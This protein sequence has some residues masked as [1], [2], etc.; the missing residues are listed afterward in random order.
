MIPQKAIKKITK[1]A[2]REIVVGHLIAYGF[3]PQTSDGIAQAEKFVAGLD[4][5]IAPSDLPNYYDGI[6]SDLITG[7][8]TAGI[9][10]IKMILEEFYFGGGASQEPEEIPVEMEIVEV[11]QKDSDDPIVV[12]VEAPFVN[13]VT[14]RT[15]R[16]I[17][18]PRVR[19]TIPKSKIPQQKKKDAATRMAESFDRRLDDLLDKIKNPDPTAPPRVRKPKQV[20]VKKSKKVKVNTDIKTDDPYKADTFNKFLGLKI[21][22]AFKR[23]ASARR[24]AKESGADPKGRGYFLKKALAFEFGGDKLS[25][26]KGTFS[27]DPSRVND[28]ALT[29]DQRFLAGIGDDI[30]PP[31]VKQSEL[32][33]TTQYNNKTG[34]QKIF[35]G[36]IDKLKNSFSKVEKGLNDLINLKKNTPDNQEAFSGLSKTVDSLKSIFKKNNDLQENIN[37]TKSKQLELS[38][39]SLEDSQAAAKE[40]SMEQQQFRSSTSEYTSSLQ[41]PEGEEGGDEEDRRRGPL[42]WLVDGMDL[43]DN[44]PGR[45]GGKKGRDGRTARERLRNQRNL[46]KG[47]PKKNPFQRAGDFLGRQKDRAGGWLSKQGDKVGDGLK[48]LRGKGDDALKFLRGKGDDIVQGGSRLGKGLVDNVGGF[49]GRFGGKLLGA[50]SRFGARAL[51]MA[52][53]V[54]SGAETKWRAEQGDS[55]GAWL[56]GIGTATSA[57]GIGT[58][59][60]G[61][62]ALATPFLEA[63]SMVADV[64]L[65][66][67]DVFNI[68][69]GR[70]FKKPEQKLS[71]GGTVPAMIGEAGP[72]M[73]IRNGQ[74][75]GNPLQS[76]APII[77]ATREVTKRA[78]TWADPI[79]NLV[80]QTTDPI[81]KQLKL[82]VI[83]TTIGIGKGALQKP[84]DTKGGGLMDTLKGFLGG[85]R[86]KGN[87]AKRTPTSPPGPSGSGQWGPLLE[88]IASKESG[89]NYEAMYPSTTLPGATTMTIS[90]VARR[91]TGAVGKYQQL[92][93]YLVGRAKAAGLNPDTDLYSP[94]NQDL[95]AGKVNI[96]I[97]RGGD[98]WL[99][100][101]IT[102]EQLMQ[103]LSMEFAALPNAQGKFYYPGQRS[104]ITPEQV[105]GALAQV[106][107]TPASTPTAPPPGSLAT[108][109]TTPTPSNLSTSAGSTSKHQGPVI[110]SSSS[111]SQSMG[112]LSAVKNPLTLPSPTPAAPPAQNTN[113]TMMPNLF[114]FP[115]AQPSVPSHSTSSEGQQAASYDSILQSIRFTRLSQQ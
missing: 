95:I 8:T 21:G 53:V 1:D 44:I 86:G 43:L 52:G 25:R 46:K 34:I 100:G 60:T 104:S 14:P 112:S 70:E 98:K 91:A 82:P 79:E 39:D 106:R 99:K 110:S 109:T 6:E 89:G 67:Y 41:E 71:E 75:S 45:R 69:T 90:E 88:L 96:G 48:G 115:S 51:P 31:P 81:A 65:L 73:L 94:A 58:A 27:K 57:A 12:K 78:G 32:F 64:G 4:Q 56:A 97:N 76:L 35:D 68:L 93:E 85:G 26:L 114:Q 24:I 5:W 18:L 54:A 77:V 63:A 80:R 33:D 103:N 10:N 107:S 72:E 28:P 9:R 23:A 102:D 47:G 38:L 29:R 74:P 49:F 40:S 101:E 83:P 19:N 62:G 20:L 59:T 105:K 13:P 30:T 55:V 36:N 17:R 2:H 113:I 42:D 84:K 11:E 15:P 108:R 61:I 111:S 16:R 66:G 50:G 7:N 37:V 87:T 92:P 3:F 22:N